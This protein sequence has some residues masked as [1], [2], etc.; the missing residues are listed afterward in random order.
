MTGRVDVDELIYQ[1]QFRQYE[2]E[3]HQ[4][5]A[6]LPREAIEKVL[7]YAKILKEIKP[8]K[9]PKIK[10]SYI[11][12]LID[13]GLSGEALKRTI[14]AIGTIDASREN[15]HSGEIWQNMLSKADKRIEEWYASLGICVDNLTEEQM[16]QLVS[17]GVKKVRRMKNGAK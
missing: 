6:E 2:E 17:E 14:E 12:Y 7:V 4:V 9:S 3:L 1:R 11:R 13:D 8:S 5:I 16:M 15:Q 10:E